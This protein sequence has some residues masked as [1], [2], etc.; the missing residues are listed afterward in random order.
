MSGT[1]NVDILPVCVSDVSG[2]ESNFGESGYPDVDDEFEGIFQRLFRAVGH[3][4]SLAVQFRL[5]QN[6]VSWRKLCPRGILRHRHPLRRPRGPASAVGS[7]AD[8]R[9]C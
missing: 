7:R 4:E 3:A 5:W 9:I 8:C 1:N 2:K 6:V